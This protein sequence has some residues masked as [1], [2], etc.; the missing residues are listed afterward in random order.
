MSRSVI[1]NEQI[2]EERKNTIN[3]AAIKLFAI[4]GY[5]TITIG[6]ICKEANC[7]HGLFYHYYKNKF[8]LLKKIFLDIQPFLIEGKRK[9]DNSNLPFISKLQ[10]IHNAIINLINEDSEKRFYLYLFL[11]FPLEKDVDQDVKTF[12]KNFIKDVAIRVG[13]KTKPKKNKKNKE[14]IDTYISYLIGLLTVKIKYPNA[15]ISTNQN[16][17]LEIF[18]KEDSL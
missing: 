3:S 17:I 6:D 7:S 4:N 16:I 18:Q 2:K 15:D 5:S 14:I 13:N 1:Q 8:D 12:F 11:V 10:T 9:L